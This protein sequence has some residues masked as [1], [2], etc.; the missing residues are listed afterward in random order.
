MT[1]D[2]Q[3]RILVLDENPVRSKIIEQGLREAGLVDIAI[4]SE[5]LGLV[6]RIY[7]LDPDVI[8]ID[9]GNPSRDLL[10]QMFQVSRTVKRPIAMFVDQW[11]ATTIK[12]AID[13]GVSAYVVDGLRKE[14]VRPIL[15]LAMVRYKAFDQLR[16]EIDDARFALEERKSIDRAKGILMKRKSLSEEEAY[17]LMQRTAMSQSR[18]MIDVATS[19]IS[20]ADLLE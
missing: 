7:R 9:L 14:R 12:S 15:E 8:L 1:T 3:L 19:I 17:A 13:A 11:D 20:V 4:V 18:K 5:F 2:T 10:E 16:K 6:D